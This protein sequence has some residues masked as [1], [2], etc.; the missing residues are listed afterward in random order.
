MILVTIDEICQMVSENV[1]AVRCTVS[2]SG[3]QIAVEFE[4]R[5]DVV[6]HLLAPYYQKKLKSGGIPKMKFHCLLMK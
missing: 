4:H 3:D 1:S 2:P 6:I 5:P